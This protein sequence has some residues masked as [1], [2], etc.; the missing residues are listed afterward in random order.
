MKNDPVDTESDVM[1]NTK[2]GFAAGH[3]LAKSLGG[4]GDSYNIFKQDAGQNNS[5]WR[6]AENEFGKFINKAHADNDVKYTMTL[7]GTSLQYDANV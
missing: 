4:P 5:E 1:D 3:M 6:S 2:Q 7:T